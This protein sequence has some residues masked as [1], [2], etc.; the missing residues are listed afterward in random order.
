VWPNCW[1]PSEPSGAPD[2][3]GALEALKASQAILCRGLVAACQT[4]QPEW[5]SGVDSR[6][7]AAALLAAL[8]RVWHTGSLPEALTG[9]DQASTLNEVSV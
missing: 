7:L 3:I 9:Q 6:L 5:Q 1:A 2:W 4:E 8:T